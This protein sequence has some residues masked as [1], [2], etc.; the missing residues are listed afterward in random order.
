MSKA[1]DTIEK[2]DSLERA[3]ETGLD[4][5]EFLLPIV[6]LDAE[7]LANTKFS[8]KP[9]DSRIRSLPYL[10][11]EGKHIGVWSRAYV[12]VNVYE[13]GTAIAIQRTWKYDYAYD[14]MRNNAMT[15]D[16]SPTKSPAPMK[17]EMTVKFYLI[18]CKHEYA[19]Q[20]SNAKDFGIVLLSMDHLHVCS[21]CGHKYV[22][23][24]SD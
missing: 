3:C 10:N 12:L 20:S 7:D 15:L 2:L 21:K 6:E 17:N 8:E 1:D 4:A 13:D 24:T 23:N 18:G 14:H 5:T 9:V 19:E 11:T 16:G 22:V